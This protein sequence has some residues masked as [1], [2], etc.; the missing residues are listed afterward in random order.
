MKVY[1]K[2]IILVLS[3][4]ISSSLMAA[5]STSFFTPTKIE[6]GGNFALVT[7]GGHGNPDGCPNTANYS[8]NRDKD[9]YKEILATLLTAKAAG[10]T[11]Q[12]FVV[13]CEGPPG[14]DYPAI[15]SVRAE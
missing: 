3:L 13:G 6:I 4:G 12:L 2:G 11:V 5:G 8:L 9:S 7:N 14:F 10:I 15:F 1:I